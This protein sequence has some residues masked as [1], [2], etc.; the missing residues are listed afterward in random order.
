MYTKNELLNCT[1]TNVCGKIDIYMYTHKGTHA[2]EKKE[3]QAFRHLKTEFWCSKRNR[4]T[5]YNNVHR[6][7]IIHMHFSLNKR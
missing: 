3:T 6:F 1:I 5:P 4:K 7:Y 2:G